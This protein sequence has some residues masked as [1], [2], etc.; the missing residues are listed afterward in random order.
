MTDWKILHY[1]PPL[2]GQLVALG[3]GADT[4]QLYQKYADAINCLYQLR[5]IPPAVCDRARGKLICAIEDYFKLARE[6]AEAAS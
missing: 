3:M 2:Y 6:K 1:S 5:W 4:A